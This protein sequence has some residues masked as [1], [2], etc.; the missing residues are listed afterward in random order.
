L[1][2][3]CSGCQPLRHSSPNVGFWVQRLGAETLLH[4]AQMLQPMHS[5]MSSGL[6]SSI[7]FGRNG[8]AIEGL[9]APIMS[10]IPR[11]MAETMASGE[12]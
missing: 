11:R 4:A 8:S 6:P 1:D 3:I 9:A 12:V 7:F 10:T 2:A 5:R